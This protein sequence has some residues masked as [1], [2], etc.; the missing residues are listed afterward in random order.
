MNTTKDNTTEN[1]TVDATMVLDKDA[2]PLP[3]ASQTDEIKSTNFTSAI[4]K[5]DI[6]S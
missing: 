6:C 3:R 2:A 4:T 5:N 1:L